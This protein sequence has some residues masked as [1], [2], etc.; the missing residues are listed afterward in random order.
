MRGELRFPDGDSSG[1]GCDLINQY[2][3]KISGPSSSPDPPE[4]QKKL[5]KYL[6]QKCCTC[7]NTGI[8]YNRES[9]GRNCSRS[10]LFAN[11]YLPSVVVV[12][13][14]QKHCMPET[15][16]GGRY[17]SP[18][19]GRLSGIENDGSSMLHPR[20]AFAGF[21]SVMEFM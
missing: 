5:I 21:L 11:V 13:L 20:F 14:K 18:A 4:C 15:E 19:R 6:K 8:D 12:G 16:G 2:Y 17:L 9:C 7:L 10:V 1:T 3:S